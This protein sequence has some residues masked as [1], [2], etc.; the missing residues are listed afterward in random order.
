MNLTK[1][2]RE[3]RFQYGLEYKHEPNPTNAAILLHKMYLIDEI[4]TIIESTKGPRVYSRKEI[5]EGRADYER[6]R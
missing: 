2:L 1:W 5:L 4:L 6:T 3:R